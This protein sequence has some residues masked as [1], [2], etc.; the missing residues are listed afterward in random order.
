MP[1]AGSQD[2]VTVLGSAP[3]GRGRDQ[4]MSSGSAIFASVSA[5]SRNRNGD[6][7]YAADCRPRLRDVNR[8]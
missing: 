3:S 8:G 5:P 1:A 2:T 7:V 6:R 4:R